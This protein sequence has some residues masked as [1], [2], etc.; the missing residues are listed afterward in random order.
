MKFIL[1]GRRRLETEDITK[2]LK[3]T[4]E[5]FSGVFCC[6]DA[7]DELEERTCH[8]LL[9][10]L[11]DPIFKEIKIFLTGRSRIQQ[12]VDR[13]FGTKPEDAIEIL[14]STGDIGIFLR[15]EI[16][17]DQDINPGVMDRHLKEEIVTTLGKN[18]KGM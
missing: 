14:A 15:Q 2:I 13:Q 11:N 5:V 12:L 3:K 4:I 7:L 1:A 16:D 18:A 6:I 9:V 8:S 17:L 10:S